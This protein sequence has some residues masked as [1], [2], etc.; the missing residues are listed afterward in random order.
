MDLFVKDLLG[1]SE[2]PPHRLY[3][4]V[5]L[6][7]LT[8]PLIDVLPNNPLIQATSATFNPPRHPSGLKTV[9]QLRGRGEV[10]N[11]AL[12]LLEDYHE[13]SVQNPLRSK[14]E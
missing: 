3:A 11:V 8:A 13:A 4:V 2:T 6:L 14:P 12:A 1:P 7:H 10:G 5:L 9:A